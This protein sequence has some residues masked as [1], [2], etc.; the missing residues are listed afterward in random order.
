MFTATR[1]AAT[2]ASRG[3]I[4]KQGV[5]NRPWKVLMYLL[6]VLLAAGFLM[7]IAWALT[8]SVKDLGGVYEFPPTFWVSD[9]QWGNYPEALGKLPFFAFLFNTLVI[10]VAAT[11]GHVLTA[12]M[13][14]YAFA[15]LKWRG[16]ELWFIIM[17]ATMMLPRQILLIPHYQ[18]PRPPAIPGNLKA[19]S[20]LT[21]PKD[22]QPIPKR[23]ATELWM[24]RNS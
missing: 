21:S 24:R 19:G 11:A 15:R 3:D 2:V 10:C 17:L 16:R 7:P 14:G 5:G 6:L 18:S 4:P 22:C 20:D 13:A 12:S 8:A 1:I 23:S 9:P